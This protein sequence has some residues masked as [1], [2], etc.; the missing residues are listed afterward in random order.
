MFGLPILTS[1]IQLILLTF[2]FNY[3]T[4]NFYK[5]K[6]MTEELNIIMNKIY[7]PEVIERKIEEIAVSKPGETI[8]Y[9][10]AL[11]GKQNRKATMVGVVLAI[12]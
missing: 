9:K 1:V 7:S 10:E 2:V 11:L 4:P 5:E 8:S 6:G 3:E 12:T